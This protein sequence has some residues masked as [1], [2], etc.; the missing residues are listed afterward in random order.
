MVRLSCPLTCRWPVEGAVAA[1][2]RLQFFDK[3]SL[4]LQDVLQPPEKQIMNSNKKLKFLYM[5]FLESV[6]TSKRTY[7]IVIIFSQLRE[8]QVL[9]NRFRRNRFLWR[10]KEEGETCFISL[11]SLEQKCF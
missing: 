3:L 9:L 10:R 8:R 4:M 7:H 11:C 1:Q 6:H 2:Y 5:S